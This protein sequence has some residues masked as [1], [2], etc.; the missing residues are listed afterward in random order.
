MPDRNENAGM[1]LTPAVCTATNPIAAVT[2]YEVNVFQLQKD[3]EDLQ[4]LRDSE[5]THAPDELLESYDR[6]IAVLQEIVNKYT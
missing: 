6:S 2:L 5:I 3:L 4:E 1:K